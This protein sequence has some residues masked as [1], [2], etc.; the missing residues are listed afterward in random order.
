[1]RVAVP[2]SRGRISPVL[3]VAQRLRLVDVVDGVAASQVEHVVCGE[4]TRELVE[5]GV[6]V[7]IC[8][9][10]SQEMERRLGAQDIEVIAGICGSVDEVVAAYVAGDL[11][12]AR[13]AIPGHGRWRQRRRTRGRADRDKRVRKTVGGA[14]HGPSPER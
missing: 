6:D 3:D 7:L 9:G 2:I 11:D 13:F 14:L 12:D 8:A 10:V 1:M 5:L 4:R